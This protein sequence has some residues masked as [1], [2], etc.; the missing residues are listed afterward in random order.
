[1]KL[2]LFC[3]AH[4]GRYSLSHITHLQ[5][6]TIESAQTHGGFD[7]IVPFHYE[8]LDDS[9]VQ[10]NA[11]TFGY[12]RGAGYW[13]WKPHLALK[14][15]D[16]SEV[17][18]DDILVYCDSKVIFTNSFRPVVDTFLRDKLDIMT[19]RQLDPSQIRT[20]RDC[21]VLMDA[22]KPEY[23][24]TCQRTANL[25]VF[26]RSLIARGFLLEMLNACSDPRILT[27]QPNTCGLP[28]YEGFI[29]H[30][31]DE[32]ILTILAKK[33]ELY[34]YRFP[35]E[36][37]SKIEWEYTRGKFTDESYSEYVQKNGS[38]QWVTTFRQYPDIVTDTKS[39]Y[40]DCITY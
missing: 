24:S 32:S 22:D 26:K 7:E 3:Y 1:M 33:Y 20:K 17:A 40:P 2:W 11:H 8:N 4:E 19:F 25:W 27:D 29:E 6:L 23:I 35:Y 30:R 28:N 15:L 10:E 31:H 5:R 18:D 38:N 36:K 9:F 34:P 21:F 14:M 16:S 37:H 39:N 12:A 13:I